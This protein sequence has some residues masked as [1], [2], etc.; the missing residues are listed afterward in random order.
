MASK[1]QLDQLMESVKDANGWSDP[2]LVRNAE[3]RGRVISKSNISR[4]RGPLE[5]IKRENILDLAAALRVAP[6]QVA[7]SAFE[8]MGFNLPTYDSPTPEQAIR[9][10][11][12]LSEKDKAI[13]LSTLQQM[14]S[15]SGAPRETSQNQEDGRRS[16]SVSRA[17]LKRR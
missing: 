12:T 17:S 15:P 4:F 2:D 14:R 16:K 13:L 6:S 8:A 3:E 5:S 10:D 9:L 7:V 11:S 1:H